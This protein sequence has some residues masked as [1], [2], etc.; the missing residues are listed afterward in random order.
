[1]T[2]FHSKILDLPIK[3]DGKIL[4]VKDYK[5]FGTRGYVEYTREEMIIIKETAGEIT[6]L[7]HACKSVFGGTIVREIV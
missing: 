1:M 5:K 6:P 2:R 3:Y 4:T 7:I